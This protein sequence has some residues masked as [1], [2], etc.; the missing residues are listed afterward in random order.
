MIV[1]DE[2]ANLER[3]FAS[4]YKTIDYYVISDTGSSDNTIEKIYELGVKYNIPGA[5]FKHPWVDFAHNRNLAWDAALKE[6]AEG[7]HSCKWLMIIDADEELIELKGNWK[8]TL[9]E[10]VSY[11]TYKK[12]EGTVFKHFFL[13]WF[14]GQTF[15][16]EGRIHNYLICLNGK[17]LKDHLSQVFIRS[18]IFEGS[19]SKPF[20]DHRE[21]ALK[22][23]RLL[24][25]ELNDKELQ[26]ENVHRYYQLGYMYRAYGDSDSAIL[27]LGKVAGFEE[28]SK[29]IRYISLILI[30]KILIR[31]R[32]DAARIREFINKAIFIDANRLEAY[33]YNAVLYR[34]LG[35]FTNALPE[36]KKA[37][38]MV[39]GETSFFYFEEDI[40]TW[41]IKYE[42]AFV[43]FLLK[44]YVKA[45]K[46]IL[47]L[48][49][50]NLAPKEE[51]KFLSSLL[52]KIKNRS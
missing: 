10:G 6:G 18:H 48:I 50:N 8:E 25:E 5:V 7:K 46:Y 44:E 45:E 47:S 49:D 3:L 34:R 32:G 51:Q 15:H 39:I 27:Y 35:D 33:Y 29:D 52:E 38:D 9:K 16:W 41:K 2:A 11:T 26:A 4:L 14:E 20:K 43:Y 21:K 12:I 13:L 19:K 42:L 17:I 31:D 24:L 40:Y 1:K 36:L 37:D 23:I 28:A 30:I 22:D